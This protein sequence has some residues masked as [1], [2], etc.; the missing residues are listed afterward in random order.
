MS[1][2]STAF[3]ARWTNDTVAL[4]KAPT[5][6]SSVTTRNPSG[7]ATLALTSAAHT[8][9]LNADTG[10]NFFLSNTKDGGFTVLDQAGPGVLQ[11]KINGAQATA[12]FDSTTILD[13]NTTEPAIGTSDYTVSKLR[14]E[15]RR[16]GEEWVRN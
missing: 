6:S 14:P 2:G 1:P 12:R 13:N 15:E 4:T 5:F 8:T 16:V 7:I 3:A 10:G 9:N 11:F